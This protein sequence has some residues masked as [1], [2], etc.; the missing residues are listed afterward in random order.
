MKTDKELAALAENHCG[1]SDRLYIGFKLGYRQAES[2]SLTE[3]TRLK[4]Q[5]GEADK[6]AEF[7]SHKEKRKGFEVSG[8]IQGH[9]FDIACVACDERNKGKR[10]R[11]YL[12][13]YKGGEK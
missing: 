4:E 8:I 10:A 2:D 13:K 3:I 6:V 1:M 9:I 12:A 7:Y 11:Q 5:L